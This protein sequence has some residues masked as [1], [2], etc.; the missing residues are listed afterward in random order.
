MTSAVAIL[1]P[2]EFSPI[3]SEKIYGKIYGKLQKQIALS[4]FLPTF[5]PLAIAALGQKVGKSFCSFYGRKGEHDKL[6]WTLNLIAV[7]TFYFLQN[8]NK[9]KFDKNQLVGLEIATNRSV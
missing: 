7:F 2:L 5:W 8:Q 1:T 9:L 3:L 6:V 4:S